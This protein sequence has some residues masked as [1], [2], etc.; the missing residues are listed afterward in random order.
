L[1]IILFVV[2]VHQSRFDPCLQYPVEKNEDTCQNRN[3]SDGIELDDS[4][5][6]QKCLGFVFEHLARV[7]GVTTTFRHLFL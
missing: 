5:R 4:H 6:S 1:R 3:T 7:F 2:F